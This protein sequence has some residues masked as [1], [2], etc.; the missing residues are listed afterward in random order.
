MPHRF[1]L[2]LDEDLRFEKKQW[3]F[4]RITWWVL[5]LVMAATALGAFGKGPISSNQLTT[6]EGA[7]AA[8]YGRFGRYGS[9][10]RLSIKAV[11]EPDG[12]VRITLNEQLIESFRVRAITPNPIAA[13][14]TSGGVEYEFAAAGS[15]RVHVLFELQ[16][17]RRWLVNGSIRSRSGT[18]QFWQFIYP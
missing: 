12:A 2:Q 1:A 14:S 3:M 4:V 5:L 6:D 8:E 7:L 15:G 16:P 11:P 17:A 13:R 10:M 18:L 9:S